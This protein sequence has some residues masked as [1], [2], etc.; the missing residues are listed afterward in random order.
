M[1]MQGPF[2]GS[3]VFSLSRLRERAYL[4]PHFRDLGEGGQAGKLLAPTSSTY[5]DYLSAET[6][7]GGSVTCHQ[8]VHVRFRQSHK[9]LGNRLLGMRKGSLC[10]R[11]V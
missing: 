7:E 5:C 11:I 1:Q 6:I 3:S 9:V 4:T 8:L 10:V 2:W